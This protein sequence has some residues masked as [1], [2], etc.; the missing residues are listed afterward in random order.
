MLPRASMPNAKIRFEKKWL[1]LL[2]ATVLLAGCTPAGPK[3]LLEGAR[4]VEQGSYPAAIEK[5]QAATTLLKT[6]AAA[7]NYLGLAYHH[8]N[9][10]ADAEQAYGKA[11]VFDRNLAE[12][13][14]NLGC[15]RLDQNQ[16]DLARGEFISYTG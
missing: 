12:V 9:R 10:F 13:R 2:A 7:W 16:P 3:A 15:L 6:N 14:F 11:L 4:L 8:A 1:C 5:L